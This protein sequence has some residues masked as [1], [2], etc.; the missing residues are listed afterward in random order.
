MEQLCTRSYH[1]SIF[2]SMLPFTKNAVTS[3]SEAH[4]KHT[5]ELH[6][7]YSNAVLQWSHALPV[8]RTVATQTI[9]D[10]LPADSYSKE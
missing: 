2:N 5:S 7:K 8:L 1:I 4:Q 3:M 6:A 10:H 9:T